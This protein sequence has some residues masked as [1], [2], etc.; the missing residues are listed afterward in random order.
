MIIK[1]D[2]F[3]FFSNKNK[4]QPMLVSSFTKL[5]IRKKFLVMSIWATRY[6]I[7]CFPKELNSLNKDKPSSAQLHEDFRKISE[8]DNH[9]AYITFL[10]GYNP[11]NHCQ[12]E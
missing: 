3:I 4:I 7:N 10:L 8:F 6:N 1:I 5:E 9:P 12:K 11:N 2:F